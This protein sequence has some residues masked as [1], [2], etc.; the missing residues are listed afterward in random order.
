MA[1]LRNEAGLLNDLCLVDK[2]DAKSVVKHLEDRF[3]SGKKIK[4]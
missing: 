2:A 1:A 4:V 3:K